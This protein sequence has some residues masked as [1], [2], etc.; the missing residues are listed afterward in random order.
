V[1]TIGGR[2]HTIEEIREVGR[3]GLPFVEMSLNDPETVLHSLPDLLEMKKTYG[4]TYLAHYPNEDNP[5]DVSIL[6]KRFV[7]RIKALID[8]SDRLS[9]NKATMHFWIDKRWAP[10]DLIPQKLEL[11]KDIVEYASQGDMVIC[12]ENLS[13]R[14][15]SFKVAFAAIPDLRMTLDIGHAQLLTKVNTS[16]G[17]IENVYEKIAHVHVHD[18]H[19]GTSVKDDLH[20][21]LGE[22]SVD[23][24]AI[25]SS[26]LRSGYDSTI[27]MEVKP[28]DMPH[29]KEALQSCINS[30]GDPS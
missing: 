23:Y 18:N 29:T 1:I 13:E 11:L 19:G 4:I 14:H 25:L 3:I 5:F 16:F 9:I 15:D 22:G 24:H 17:F 28:L 26:L 8:L 12:I 20:L 27:S 7:P 6:K 30:V 2:A 21:A 10:E